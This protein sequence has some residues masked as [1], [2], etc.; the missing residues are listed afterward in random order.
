MGNIIKSVR[1]MDDELNKFKRNI[2]IV[3][4][5]SS[6][7]YQIDK[8]ETSKCCV[9]MRKDNAKIGIATDTDGHGIFYNFRK[10]KGGSIIDFVQFETGKNLGQIRKELRPWI[11]LAKKQIFSN[12]KPVK[13]TKDR[14]AVIIKFARTKS[15]NFHKDFEER[16]IKQNIIDSDRFSGRIHIDDS[17]N[18]IFPHYDHEGVCGYS[19]RNQ[20]YKSFLRG[21]EKGLWSSNFK[22]DDS[23]IVICESVIDALSYHQLKDDNLTS[24]IAIDGQLTNKQLMLITDLIL[25]NSNKQIVLAFDNDQAGRKFVSMIKKSNMNAF[26]IVVDLPNKYGHDWNDILVESG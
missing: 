14:Q 5:A 9:I 3:N 7:G 24:Y 4:Y 20:N 6:L 21:G 17:G 2:N 18:V 23:Q 12:Y 13:S 19:I 1:D 10:D 16:G 15:V 11:G 25:R 8:Q 22:Q 26:N